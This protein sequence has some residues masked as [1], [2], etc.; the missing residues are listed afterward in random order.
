MSKLMRILVK[1]QK[2]K[3]SEKS[4]SLINKKPRK[5]DPKPEPEPEPELK[6]ESESEPE[7]EPEPK[8]ESQPELELKKGES[9]K[10]TEK[11]IFKRFFSKEKKFL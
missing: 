6:L 5:P 8:Q 4:F 10:H 1:K 7:S 9:P 2:L 3:K 11:S